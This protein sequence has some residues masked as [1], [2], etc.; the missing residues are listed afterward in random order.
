MLR[1]GV[2]ALDET[3]KVQNQT[4]EGKQ[5]SPGKQKSLSKGF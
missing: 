5:H 2:S 3:T 4:E 1:A